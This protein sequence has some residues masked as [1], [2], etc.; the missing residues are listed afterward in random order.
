MPHCILE[1]SD[2]LIEIINK[3]ELLL[4]INKCIE[5]TGLFNIND[6]KSR[7]VVHTNYVIGDGDVNRA[8]VTLNVAILSG[9]NQETK[10]MIS[11]KCLE[12]LRPIFRESMKKLKFSLTVQITEIDKES[13]AKEKSY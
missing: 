7:Y 3:K 12:I 8:F 5:E 6:I 4:Q 1:T 2:N 11:N 10:N 13:Y 9:R